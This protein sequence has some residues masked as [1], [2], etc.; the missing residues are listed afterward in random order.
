MH[1]YH[2]YANFGMHWSNV[3]HL[4]I[5]RTGSCWKERERKMLTNLLSQVRNVYYNYNSYVMLIMNN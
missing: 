4:P 1:L 2:L 3:G 5:K